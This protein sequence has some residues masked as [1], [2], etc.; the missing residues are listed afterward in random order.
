MKHTKIIALL[1][2][3][4]MAAATLLGCTGGTDTPVTTPDAG[5]Q[6]STQTNAPDGGSTE[7]PSTGD[8][9]YKEEIVIAMADEFTTIDPMETTAETNQIVQDCT[10]D[11]LTD[12]NLTTMQNEGELVDHWEMLAPDHWRFVLKDNVTFHDGTILNVDDV[13]FTFQ[14][15]AEKSTTANYMAKISEFIKVDE[16]GCPMEGVKFALEDEDGNVLRELASGEDGIVHADDLKPGVYIIRE[17]ETQ[18]GYRLTEETIR[19]VIDENYI[20]P[21]ELFRLVNFP[22]EER[23][24]DEIQ[25]GVDVPVT[26]MMRFGVAS[27]ICGMAIFV[28]RAIKKRGMRSID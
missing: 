11:L 26:P 4:V 3:I 14:R 12:T 19:V 22:E 28:L 15:A 7:Q 8:V 18:A 6:G 5:Q 16:D 9:K 10:H 2:C 1:L 27:V 23:P 21:D 13:E 25:T 24:R 17:I 20:A